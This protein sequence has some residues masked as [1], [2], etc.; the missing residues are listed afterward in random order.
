MSTTAMIHVRLDEPLKIEATAVLEAMGL[1]LSDA[2]RIFL[3]HMVTEKKFPFVLTVPNLE[4]SQAME[5]ARAMT[6]VRLDTQ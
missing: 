2:I 1:S 5:E 3:T 6:K 4:T